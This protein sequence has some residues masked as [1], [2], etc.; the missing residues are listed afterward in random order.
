MED[1]YRIVDLPY[2]EKVK[3]YMKST[4]E[5]L[6]HMLAERD[7]ISKNFEEITYPYPPSFLTFFTV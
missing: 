5:E 2:E 6:A 7:E 4:K 1:N 3:L